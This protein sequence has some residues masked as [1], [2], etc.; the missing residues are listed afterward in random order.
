M[1][2]AIQK[3]LKLDSK[4]DGIQASIPDVISYYFSANLKGICHGGDMAF[5]YTSMMATA[6]GQLTREDRQGIDDVVKIWT[7][8][9]KTGKP[10]AIWEPVELGN[11]KY[12]NIDKK[13]T[14][15]P[16]VPFAERTAFW[17]NIISEVPGF[18]AGH[19]LKPK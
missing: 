12:L 4:Y 17:E 1:A 8:F 2:H 3:L 6:V 10:H 14:L 13:M 7:D 9:A 15:V 11:I 16:G 18:D 5:L 19:N